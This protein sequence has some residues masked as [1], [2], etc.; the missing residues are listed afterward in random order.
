LEEF[1]RAQQSDEGENLTLGDAIKRHR[2]GTERLQRLW[3]EPED[4]PN[5][6]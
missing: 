4:E 6:E 2:E 5:K 1:Q 3:E